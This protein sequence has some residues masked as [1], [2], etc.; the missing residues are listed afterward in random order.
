MKTL[1]SY[2][3]L[4][5]HLLWYE[6][7]VSCCCVIGRYHRA[8]SISADSP[9]CFCTPVSIL[10]P[11]EYRCGPALSAD[12]SCEQMYGEDGEAEGFP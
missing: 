10:V 2:F 11:G 9:E 7:P 5:F 12:A 6:V 4:E 1:S 8:C 3:L